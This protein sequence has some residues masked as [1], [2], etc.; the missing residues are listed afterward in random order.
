MI[1]CSTAMLMLMAG[2]GCGDVAAREGPPPVLTV[3]IGMPV[4]RLNRQ[5]PVAA[6]SSSLS[7]SR[8]HFISVDSSHV[9]ALSVNGHSLR[10]NVNGARSPSYIQNGLL[11]RTSSSP[12]EFPIDFSRVAA[13]SFG[14]TAGPVL[15]TE[16]ISAARSACDA[17]AAAGLPRDPKRPFAY[18]THG[19]PGATVNL[20]SYEDVAAALARPA[21]NASAVS[22]CDLK[23]SESVFSLE[24]TNP[25]RALAAAGNDP[26]RES[27]QGDYRLEAYLSQRNPG[28]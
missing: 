1:R 28:Y 15:L 22:L 7:S 17:F 26:V 5:T 3:E 4:E 16:V 14:V 8:A 10:Y 2:S 9:L 13:I 6:Q 18:I 21:L 20:T 25:R 23:D 12:S 11:R 19:A 24:I 27:P